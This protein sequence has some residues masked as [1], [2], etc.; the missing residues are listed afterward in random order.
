VLVAHLSDLHL[1]DAGDAVWMERQLDR[2]VAR[3]PDHLAITGD[4]LDRWA[5]WLVEYVLDAIAARGLL[6]PERL[7]ILHGNHDFASSGGHPRDRR[8]LW[9]LALRFWDPPPLLRRRR[10]R[11]YQT[12]ADR[13]P[14]VSSPAPFLKSLR[15]GLRVAVVD[16]IPFPWTPISLRNGTVTLTHAIGAISVAQSAWLAAQPRAA[17]PLVVLMHHYPLDSP[18]Y[19]WKPEGLPIG[20]MPT[21]HVPMHLP[22]DDRTAF[23]NAAESAD[24]RLVLCGHVHRARLEWHRGIAVG[25]NGQSG[26]GWAGRCIAWYDLT[27]D[28]MTMALESINQ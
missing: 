23:W 25:L 1:R 3:Q 10:R 11:F 28:R 6:D 4:L 20:R 21:V 15:C 12:I 22:D 5:P 16:T 7:T 17:E 19:A 18:S 9:R 13:A 24:A 14:G 8:D 26:A 2:I 27:G